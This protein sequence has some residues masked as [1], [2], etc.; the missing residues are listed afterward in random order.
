LTTDARFRGVFA[1]AVTP[2]TDDGESIDET[3]LRKLLDYLLEEKVHG[4]AMFGSTGAVGAFTEDER[5]RVAEVT[6]KHVNGRVPVMIGTGAISTGEALRLSRHAQDVGADA[7]LVVPVTYWIPNDAELFEH[8][9]TLAK[10]IRIPL[11]V[12]NSPRL[13]GLDM[14]PAFLARLAQ[15]DNIRFM[16]ESSPDLSRITAVARLSNDRLRVLTG[17]DS[18]ALEAFILGAKGWCAG[19]ANIIP[20]YCVDLFDLAEKGD[21]KAAWDL[22]RRLFPITDFALEKGLIRSSHTALELMGRPM[23]PPRK[24]INM[25]PAGDRERLAKLLRDLGITVR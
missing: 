1:F 15:F 20:R 3:R 4:V 23:G 14:S 17:R 24:P 21:L 22:S 9:E 25:L 19:S 5:R 12:Y 11:C 6:V 10:A 7:V 8:Y 16:K 18:T 2:T 13:A